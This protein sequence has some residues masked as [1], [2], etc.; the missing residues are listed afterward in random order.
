[1]CIIDPNDKPKKLKKAN[2]LGLLDA[3]PTINN[4]YFRKYRPEYL[5]YGPG[6]D[7]QC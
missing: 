6:F 4:F 3:D 7:E 2:L 5:W 1:M